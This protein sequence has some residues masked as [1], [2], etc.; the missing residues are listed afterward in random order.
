MATVKR[1]ARSIIFY[2][3]QYANWVQGMGQA[4]VARA[5]C[6]NCAHAVQ[7]KCEQSLCF[8]RLLGAFLTRSPD[9]NVQNCTYIAKCHAST[10]DTRQQWPIFALPRKQRMCNMRPPSEGAIDVYRLIFPAR[11]IHFDFWPT[12]PMQA[13]EIAGC[14]ISLVSI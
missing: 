14:G 4:V 11:N 6:A 3:R 9:I 1:Q 10:D 12:S 7:A 2:M 8:A 13:L 5:F